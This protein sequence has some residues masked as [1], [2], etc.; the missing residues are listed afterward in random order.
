M[1]KVKFII[2]TIALALLLGEASASC[3]LD[4]G[5]FAKTKCDVVDATKKTEPYL[6]KTECKSQ[7]KNGIMKSADLEEKRQKW[8]KHFDEQFKADPTIRV[9]YPGAFRLL[10]SENVFEFEFWNIYSQISRRK[11]EAIIKNDLKAAKV[12]VVSLSFF[13]KR[14]LKT[15]G[16]TSK[17]EFEGLIDSMQIPISQK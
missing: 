14:S 17:Y 9:E 6:H 1:K 11:I 7:D 15:I 10:T 3:V 2:Q 4:S 8:W 13:E 5:V 12:K 16:D